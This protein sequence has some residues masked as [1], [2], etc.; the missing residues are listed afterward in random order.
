MIDSDDSKIV[1]LVA[2]INE[3]DN[4]TFPIDFNLAV[5]PHVAQ[6]HSDTGTYWK[7]S[8]SNMRH[9]IRHTK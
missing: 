3:K 6:K 7:T 1:L 5:W 8:W 4:L 9:S 2:N